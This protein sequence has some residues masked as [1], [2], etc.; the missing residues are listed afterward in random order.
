MSERVA[1]GFRTELHFADE[2]MRTGVNFDFNLNGATANL[3][4]VLVYEAPPINSL[5]VLKASATSASI[6]K[7]SVVVDDPPSSEISEAYS[8]IRSAVDD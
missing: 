4:S 8:N 7:G 3:G 5:F 6:S 2:L 1:Y